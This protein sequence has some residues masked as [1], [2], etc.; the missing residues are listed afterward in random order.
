M[1]DA[2]P[3]EKLRRYLRELKPE[4]RELLAAELERAMLRGEGPPGASSILQALRDEL[5]KGTGKL[6]RLANPQRLFFAPLEP[7]LVDDAPERKHH[8]RISRSSLDPIWNWI[9]RDLVARRAKNYVEQVELLLAADETNGAEQVARAFQ[10]LVEQH[11]SERL[12]KLK[13]HEKETRRLAGQIGTPH[14]LDEVRELA[15]ILR[16]RDALGLIGSRLPPVIS[17]LGEEQIQNV[18]ALLESPIGR[19]RDVFLYALL[20]V[21]SRLGSPWQLIRLATHAASSDVAARI[22]GT[23]FAVA[24]GVV[25]TDL[26]RVVGNLEDS[27]HERRTGDVARLLK[28][29]HDA[30]RALHT[31]MDLSVLDTPWGRQLA[32]SRA[33]VAKVLHAH[34]DNLPGQVRRVLR[35]RP[36]GEAGPDAVLDEEDV[37]DIEARLNLAITC[38]RYSGE[39]AISETTRRVHSELHDYFDSGI[40][41]LLERLRA[42]P[43]GERSFR[44]SQVDA[45]VKFCGILFGPEYAG[46][47][48]KAAD[49][50]AKGEL[51]AA[52]A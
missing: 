32:D 41:V 10:D 19:H 16:A 49:I 1:A 39:L 27:L 7:F 4:A 30:A 24:V 9:C 14:A 22:A 18:T 47:L 12:S 28:E 26:N 6:A 37:A 5:R 20:V 52:K 34:I 15:A 25:L 48:A 29:F 35:P 11:L 38:R 43:A 23:P 44:Q 31:E 40:Q 42:S 50:A 21:M 33:E 3:N 36:T 8:G 45:A 13:G 51:T 17:N 46:L 2:L